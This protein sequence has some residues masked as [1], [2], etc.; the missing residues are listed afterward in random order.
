ML[1]LHQKADTKLRDVFIVIQ[2]G[3]LFHQI[4][5]IFEEVGLE[6]I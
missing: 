1:G 2:L 6:L 3:A 5:L 4:F